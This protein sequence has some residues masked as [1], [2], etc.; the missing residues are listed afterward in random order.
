MPLAPSTG[1]CYSWVDASSASSVG[2]SWLA[3]VRAAL[4]LKMF[5]QIPGGAQQCN[6]SASLTKEK[7]LSLAN[8]LRR[9]LS[10]ILAV[11]AD[12]GLFCVWSWL[13][14]YRY[15]LIQMDLSSYGIDHWAFETQRAGTSKLTYTF[16]IG[17]FRGQNEEVICSPFCPLNVLI[18]KL[19]VVFDRSKGG[20]T[21]TTLLSTR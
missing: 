6:I 9:P 7:R 21:R 17:A 14:I 1:K 15:K 18:W 20:K 16:Y 8:M 4:A 19:Y 2:R 5:W 3:S 10:A 11:W 12:A 13:H